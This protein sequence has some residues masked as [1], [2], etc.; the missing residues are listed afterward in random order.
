MSRLMTLMLRGKSAHENLRLLARRELDLVAAE[1]PTPALRTAAA[2]LATLARSAADRSESDPEGWGRPEASTPLARLHGSVL[3]AA[4]AAEEAWWAGKNDGADP[5]RLQR[6]Q[7]EVEHF[8]TRA[9]TAWDAPD[10]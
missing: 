9:R 4:L 5:D 3:Y 1:G 6:Y 7:R 10:Q 8:L 2:E